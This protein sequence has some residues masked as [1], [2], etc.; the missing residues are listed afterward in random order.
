MPIELILYYHSSFAVI[1]HLIKVYTRKLRF[2]D[3]NAE[4]WEAWGQCSDTPNGFYLN[5][6]AVGQKEITLQTDGT[7]M[8]PVP[9]H[10]VEFFLLASVLD[11]T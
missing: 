2:L 8:W 4:V 6:K 3:S 9:C 10:P 1:V 5:I 7:N 11:S